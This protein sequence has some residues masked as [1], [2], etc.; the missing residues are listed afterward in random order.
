MTQTWGRVGTNGGLYEYIITITNRRFFRL[1]VWVSSSSAMPCIEGTKAFNTP[2]HHPNLRI[3]SSRSAVGASFL[4]L[5]GLRVC[6]AIPTTLD[7]TQ[8]LIFRVHSRDVVH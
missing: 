8:T 1:K 4:H 5:R 2:T 6:I 3:T 7:F